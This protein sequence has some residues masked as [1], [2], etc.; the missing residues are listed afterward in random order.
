VDANPFFMPQD[1]H[2]RANLTRK[3][4]YLDEEVNTICY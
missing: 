1:L 2:G 4:K 3:L